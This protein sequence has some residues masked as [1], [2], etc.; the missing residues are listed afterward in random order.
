M[1][2]GQV[3]INAEKRPILLRGGPKEEKKKK[4]VKC[5][6]IFLPTASA[7]ARKGK[8]RETGAAVEATPDGRIYGVAVREKRNRKIGRV[9]TQDF[10]NSFVL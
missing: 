1:D 7:E 6:H 10:T 5:S 8:A 4:Q 3:S 2:R 9:P